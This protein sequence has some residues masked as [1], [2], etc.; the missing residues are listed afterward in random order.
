M[1]EKEINIGQEKQN[2]PGRCFWPPEMSGFHWNRPET[3]WKRTGTCYAVR[4]GSIKDNIAQRT[5]KRRVEYHFF[6]NEI[7]RR[8]HP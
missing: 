3:Y 8:K 1:A 5:I 7:I 2:C 4:D 6:S